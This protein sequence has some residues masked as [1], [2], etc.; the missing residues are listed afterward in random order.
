MDDRLRKSYNMVM[1]LLLGLIFGIS[2]ALLDVPVLTH[3]LYTGS[4]L[5]GLA[6]TVLALSSIDKSLSN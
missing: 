3:V 6:F 5:C 2:G 1:F 4:A